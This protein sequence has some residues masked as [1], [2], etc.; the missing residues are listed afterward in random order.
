MVFIL[1][2]VNGIEIIYLEVNAC[3][4]ISYI[5]HILYT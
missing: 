4:L 2:M 5:I 1:S 3:V